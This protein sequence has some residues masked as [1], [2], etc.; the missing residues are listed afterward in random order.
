MENSAAGSEMYRLVEELYPICRRITGDGVR[1]TLEIVKKHIPLR[2]YEVPTGTTVFDWV[3]PKEWNI[4]GAYL[5]NSRGEKIVDFKDSNLHVLNYSVPVHKRVSLQ[6]LKQHVFTS[7]EHPDWIPYRTSYYQENWGFCM[8]HSRY[9]ALEEGEYEVM[10]DATLENGAMTLGELVIPGE[11]DEEILVSTHTCHPSLCNDNLSGIALCTFLAKR[12]G[13][14]RPHYTYRFLFIPG[15]IG[16][17]AWLA[18][19]E[20]KLASISMGIVVTLVGDSSSFVYKKTRKGD[21]L[22]DA[23]VLHTLKHS[24]DTYSVRE[25]IPYGYDERQYSS[26]GINLQVG[27]LTRT[28]FGEFPQYHTSADNLE[29]VKPDKLAEALSV[30]QRIFYVLENNRTYRNLNPKCEP[31]LGRRGLYR[32]TGGTNEKQLNQMAIL[33]VLNYSDENHSLLQIAEKSGLPFTDVRLA[34]D[35]LL[36]CNLL[37]EVV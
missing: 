14:T 29:F 5:A 10:I 15:T 28:P 12:L 11:S 23:A 33:W 36:Q 13:E 30:Y 18:L 8:T 3:V 19:N 25:F 4:R 26:P 16:S 1:Q 34:A 32:N 27:C 2:T 21:S 22:L 7:E 6:E 9:L 31:Q 24:V 17:I 20:D 37:E 35:A